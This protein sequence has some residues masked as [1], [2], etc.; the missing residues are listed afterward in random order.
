MLG[1]SAIV[2]SSASSLPRSL[3]F[4]GGSCSGSSTTMTWFPRA[5][6]PTASQ[7]GICDAST[8]IT[9]SN[10]FASADKY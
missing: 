1:K 2:S 10:G 9:T 8:T 6:A 7:T 3:T 4:V 5:N